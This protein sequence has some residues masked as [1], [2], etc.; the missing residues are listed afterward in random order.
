MTTDR[1]WQHLKDRLPWVFNILEEEGAEGHWYE[2]DTTEP[3]SSRL[4]L[5]FRKK[6]GELESVT[7]E[8]HH[9]QDEHGERVRDWARRCKIDAQKPER[10]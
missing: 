6:N 7:I 10:S 9:T 4:T 2:Y 5:Y 3:L 1:R 8:P